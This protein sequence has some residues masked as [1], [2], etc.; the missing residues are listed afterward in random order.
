MASDNDGGPVLV[1]VE[2]RDFHT[3]AEFGLHLETFRRLDVLKV[4]AAKGRLQRCDNLDHPIDLAGVDLDVEDINAGEFLEQNRL[5]L[6]DWLAG[7]R[8]DV[9]E[10]K[11]GA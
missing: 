5:A 3:L 7:E 4:D 10:A 2:H 1:V 9:A 8:P 11:H 6:H